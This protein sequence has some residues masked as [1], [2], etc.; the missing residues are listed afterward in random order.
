MPGSIVFNIASL[1]VYTVASGMVSGF[2]RLLMGGHKTVFQCNQ[3]EKQFLPL[4][5]IPQ[6][7]GT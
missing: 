4:F 6:G 5:P 3:A 2:F 7:A 1:S